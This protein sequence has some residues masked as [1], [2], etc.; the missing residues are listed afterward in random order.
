MCKT[1]PASAE[2]RGLIEQ[3]LIYYELFSLKMTWYKKT[4]TNTVSE[5]SGM[6]Q[7]NLE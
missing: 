5:E 2:I 1:L 7:N 6:H 3:Q 4:N